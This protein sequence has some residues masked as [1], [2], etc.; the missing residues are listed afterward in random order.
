MKIGILLPTREAI[1]SGRPAA[2]PLLDLAER[3]ETAGFDSVWVGDSLLAR[4]RFEPLT[5]LA[6]AA[7]RTRRVTL[8]TAVLLPALRH[9]LLLAH[10]LAT[11]DRVAEGRLV[12]GVGIAS[13][14]PATRKEFE[15]AGVPFTQRA[16]RLAET[17][18]LCRALWG[19]ERVS[20]S[21]KYWTLEGAEL[22]PKPTQAGGPPIWMGGSGDTA[23]RWAGQRF[24]GWFPNSPTP[25][26]FRNGWTRVQ[27]T[28]RDAERPLSGVTPALY[29]TVALNPNARAAE[30]EL[31][32]FVEGYY[33][34]PYE[35]IAS[36][37]G[38]YAGPPEGCVEWLRKFAEVGVRHVVLRFAGPDQLPQL[39][40]AAAVLL[41]RLGGES[42]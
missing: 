2:A 33:M 26:T 4:P 9:P 27:A 7:A 20:V 21:G 12:L 6:A 40:R 13:D 29:T 38:C 5:L 24:D 37:Q 41:P 23:L 25:E 10:A 8:G 42:A 30:T 11:L 22:H 32:R 3:A 36:R 28:T 34:V 18:S 16:G 1:M 14:T 31:R 35:T 17:M 15:A 19:S 39:D